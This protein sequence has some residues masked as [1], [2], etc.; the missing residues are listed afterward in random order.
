MTMNQQIQPHNEKVAA[1]WSSGGRAYDDI[2]RFIAEGI[3]HCVIR[4]APK[5]GERV[6][7]IAT[8][9]GWTSRRVAEHG[10]KVTGIDIAEGMLAA[11]REIAGERGL[12][13]EYR[14]ADAE[15]L[16]FADGE[17]D[18]V[19]STCGVMFAANR[20]AAAAEL[21]RVCR[22]GGRLALLT[23]TPE[24]SAAEM[25]KVLA[26]FMTP[27]PSPPPSPFDWGRP[28]WLEETL[29]PA[30]EFGFETGTLY[31][32]ETD[33]VAAF[34]VLA[35][36]FGPVKALIESLDD[37]H[38]ASAR[39]DL[40]AFYERYRDGIGVAMPYDYLIAVGTRR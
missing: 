11:A 10:A 40:V 9:T 18:A 30:F 29:G 16:P 22:K 31:H 20:E 21:A 4:L 6:L 13:I 28:E 33:G 12:D 32:R 36:G 35:A 2:S 26:P 3:E 7:D 15:A 17:F 1:M 25:R 14:L 37:E 8:G 23:W 24:S 39:D 27:P 34:E 38:R 19:I 5:P